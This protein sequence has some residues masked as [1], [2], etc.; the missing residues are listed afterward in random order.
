MKDVGACDKLRL[1]GK[2][3]MTRRFLNGETRRPLWAVTRKGAN[4]EN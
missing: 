4:A 3:A 2:Q 1:A